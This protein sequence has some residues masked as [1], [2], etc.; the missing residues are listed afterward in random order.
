MNRWRKQWLWPR[1]VKLFHLCKAEDLRENTLL[2]FSCQRYSQ[3]TWNAMLCWRW[4][5][6]P[7][8]QPW[9]TMMNT[10]TRFRVISTKFFRGR[11]ITLCLT[12][13]MART[14]HIS[15]REMN[16]VMRTCVCEKS[17]EGNRQPI[18]RWQTQLQY[19][20]NS[21]ARLRKLFD[22]ESNRLCESDC[23]LEH[24]S[25]LKVSWIRSRLI[26]LSDVGHKPNYIMVNSVVFSLLN[27]LV[28]WNFYISVQFTVCL[29][30]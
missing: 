24:K 1:G 10:W 14:D 11:I 23:N 16:E 27:D 4:N 5:D 30:T 19:D 28:F 13:T 26:L 2:A 25:D 7:W 21:C 22:S 15:Q 29:Y 9:F 17:A 6:R 20:L 18:N 3:N 12:I 8:G